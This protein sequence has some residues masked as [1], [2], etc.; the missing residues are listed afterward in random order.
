MGSR[1]KVKGA[2]VGTTLANASLWLIVAW[3]MLAGELD[4]G[5]LQAV[6]TQLLGKELRLP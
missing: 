3:E 6:L 1:N 4:R 5:Q 2:Q